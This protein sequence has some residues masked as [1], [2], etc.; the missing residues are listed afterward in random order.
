VLNY[1]NSGAEAGENA[2][3]SLTS[4]F[5][6][7]EGDWSAKRVGVAAI[8]FASMLSGL[9]TALTQHALQG[10]DRNSFLFSAEL[11]VFGIIFL[12]LKMAVSGSFSALTLADFAGWTWLSCVPVVSQA[13]GGLIVGLVTKHAGGVLKGF[14]LIAGTPLYMCG[15]SHNNS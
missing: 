2:C 14:A 5:S 15:C 6:L 4:V 7:T 9:S 13:L 10:Q 3:A 1:S 8:M 11:A 12:L